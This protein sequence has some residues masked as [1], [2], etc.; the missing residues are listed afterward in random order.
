MT[1]ASTRDL[2]QRVRRLLEPGEIELA[3]LIVHTS[4]G[5]DEEIEMYDATLEVGDILAS[6]AGVEDWYVYSGNDDSSFSSNQHQGLTLADDEFLWEC[7]QLLRDGTFDIVV[8]F[9]ASIR[10]EGV[11][12]DVE[13]AGYEVTGVPAP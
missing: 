5:S 11:L 6:H 13:G 7:Q 9:D 1:D 8:Y 10:L 3:G 2:I 12:D 4:Y